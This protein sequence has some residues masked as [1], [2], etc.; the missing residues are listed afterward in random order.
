M[1]AARSPSTA[2]PVDAVVDGLGLIIACCDARSTRVIHVFTTLAGPWAGTRSQLIERAI[3]VD[4]RPR[5][6]PLRPEARCTDQ[7]PASR[8]LLAVAASAVPA[9][10]NMVPRSRIW[11]SWS[12]YRRSPTSLNSGR[13]SRR[14]LNHAA[15][16]TPE[17]V[18]SSEIVIL[19]PS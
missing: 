2:R 4:A 8:V 10:S 11:L 15:G 19:K 17:T 18:Q 7:Y 14:C 5:R 1:S 3:E 13:P 6:P 16:I 9:E 12:C